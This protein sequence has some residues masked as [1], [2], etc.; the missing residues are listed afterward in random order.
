LHYF[1]Q[2]ASLEKAELIFKLKTLILK[3]YYSKL[4]FNINIINAVKY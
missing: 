3:C 4:I 2:S 1:F